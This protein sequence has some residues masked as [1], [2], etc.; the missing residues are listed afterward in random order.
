MRQSVNRPRR[1]NDNA[2]MES[3]NK[4]MKSDM[5]HRR[6]FDTDRALRQAI[7]SYVRFYNHQRLHSAPGY[8]SP[9]AFEQ[10]CA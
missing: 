6:S 4:S 8:R 1:M 2:H 3:W 9:I 7:H 5:Y 10:Q